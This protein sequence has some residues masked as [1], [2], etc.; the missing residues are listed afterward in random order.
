[1]SSLLVGLWVHV[2]MKTPPEHVVFQQKAEVYTMQSNWLL[3]FTVD[4][5]SYGLFLEQVRNNI[6]LSDWL[7]GRAI[8]TAGNHAT[9]DGVYRRLFANQQVDL[10]SIKDGYQ[11]CMDRYDEV[12]QLS[13][14]V[15]WRRRSLLPFMGKLLDGLFGVVSEERLDVVTQQ[16]QALIKGQVDIVHAIDE[17]ILNITRVELKENRHAINTII[18]VTRELNRWLEGTTGQIVNSLLPFKHFVL[19]YLQI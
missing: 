14:R 4:L 18:E 2:Q 16:I 7:I 5:G 1:M 12:R 13:S 17:N 3:G 6:N 19:A 11:L 15:R 9:S 8:E 10:R